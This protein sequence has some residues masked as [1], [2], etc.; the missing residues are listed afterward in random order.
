MTV[1]DRYADRATIEVVNGSF[2][3]ALD[4]A[5]DR[6]RDGS[7]D[8]FVSA[9]ANATILRNAL[10]APVATIKLSGFDILVALLHALVYF[11]TG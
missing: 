10:D 1:L 9:G 6:L 3:A 8:V 5:Q 11:E 7:A 2:E 4:A